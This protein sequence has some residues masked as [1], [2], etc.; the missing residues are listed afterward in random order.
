MNGKLKDAFEQKIVPHLTVEDDLE[1]WLFAFETLLSDID[2]LHPVKSK[3]QEIFLQIGACSHWLRPHQMRWTAAGGFAWPE[4]YLQKYKD[5][6]KNS[7]GPIGSGL[8]EL[9]W[10]VL[11]HWNSEEQEWQMVAPKFFGKKR[12]VCRAALPTR[13]ARH[14]QAAV[15]TIWMPRSSDDRAQKEVRF[16]GF[17]KQDHKW[18]CVAA[19]N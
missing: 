10:S 8:P 3:K 18:Q 5:H 11:M 2:A 14:Q 13:T 19:G 15:H 4:G 6:V 16:Y 1:F 7:W 9:E 17:R 12:I